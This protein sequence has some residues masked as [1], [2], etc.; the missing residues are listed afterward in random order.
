MKKY[1]IKNS[2][3]SGKVFIISLIRIN[4]CLYNIKYMLKVKV[5]DFNYKGYLF[6]DKN[7]TDLK[8]IYNIDF[9]S[10]GKWVKCDPN[11]YNV[12]FSIH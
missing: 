6:F 4:D 1:N 2:Y 10:I 7:I 3:Y 12:L 11:Y 9:N 5:N 8:F